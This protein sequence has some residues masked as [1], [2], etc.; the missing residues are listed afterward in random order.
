[1]RI[2]NRS[3]LLLSSLALVVG[4]PVLWAQQDSTPP[5]VDWLASLISWIPFLLILA[6]WF[7]FWSY[8]RSAKALRERSL[9]H[10]NRVEALLERIAQAVETNDDR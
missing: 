6:V 10:M 4:S 8:L 5:S 9:N 2:L 7:Y 3:L 1:M